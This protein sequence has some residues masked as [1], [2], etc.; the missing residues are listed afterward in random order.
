MCT[1]H[2]RCELHKNSFVPSRIP[3]IDALPEVLVNL[4]TLSAC[5]PQISKY[6]LSYG[7]NKSS[8]FIITNILSSVKS[9]WHWKKQDT[10]LFS[11][12]L[13]Q[14]VLLNV[15]FNNIHIGSDFD[16]PPP[17]V[18]SEQTDQKRLSL[19]L[20]VIHVFFHK[21]P[22]YKKLQGRKIKKLRVLSSKF[23]D[24]FYIR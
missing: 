15:T 20:R 11:K 23:L 6:W 13:S 18:A 1:T 4:T 9:I 22:V 2:C 17:I 5:P 8:F 16:Y 12:S 21:K 3:C 19:T 14:V 10:G 7:N 24:I